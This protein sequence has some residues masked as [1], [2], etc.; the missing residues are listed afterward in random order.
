VQNTT[1]SRLLSASSIVLAVAFAGSAFAQTPAVDPTKPVTPA[2]AA[3]P[4]PAPATTTPAAA[5]ARAVESIVVT[6]S[7]IK[8]DAFSST[9]PIQVITNEDAE[10]EGIADAAEVIQGSTQ[11]SS[12]FQINSTFTGFVVEG[13]G[14][15]NS[16][17]LRGLGAQRSLILL[18]GKRMPPS[19]VRGQVGAVDLNALPGSMVSRYEFLKDGAS[20]IYGSDAIGGVINIITKT[21]QDGGFANAYYSG[22]ED[23]GGNTT[24]LDVSYGWNFDRGNIL[25]GAEYF[26]RTDLQV[27]DRDYLACSEDYVFNPD[28]GARADI[29]D[30]LTG[31]NKCFNLFQQTARVQAGATRGEWILDPSITTGATAGW[32]QIRVQAAGQPA[33]PTSVFLP[34]RPYRSAKS[35][36]RSALSPAERTTLFASGRYQ[37]PFGE[38]VEIKAEAL[39][40]LRKSEQNSFAQL[41]AFTGNQFQPAGFAGN[42][43][44]A[45]ADVL[46]LRPAFNEQEVTTTRFNVTLSGGFGDAIPFMND[47]TWEVYAQ[48]GKGQGDYGG[49]IIV[50]DAAGAGTGP[51]YEALRGCPTGSAA[52][53]KPFSWFNRDIVANGLTREDLSFIGA[54]EQGST[55]YKQDLFEASISGTLFKLPAGELGFATGLHFRTESINDV[56]GEF[57]R[58]GRNLFGTAAGITKGTDKVREAYVELDIPL[59][60]DAP[61]AERL[62]M[63]LSG[64]YTDYD[65]YGEDSVYKAALL[66]QIV[67]AV[68]FSTTYGTNY[69]A[70]A[71]YELFLA[72][73]SGFQGQGAI[74]ACVDWDTDPNAT[75]VRTCRALGLPPG[76]Q[77]V[78]PTATVFTGGGKGVLESETAD[79]FT[80]TLTWTPSFADL[81]IA[82]TYYEVEINNA[83]DQLGAANIVSLCQQ[84]RPGP[85]CGLFNRDLTG[86]AAT[87]PNFGSILTVQNSYIN[88]A[89]LRGRGI[90][91]E[92]RYRKE[93]SFGKL[94]INSSL[95]WNL[96][97]S[98]ELLGDVTNAEGLIYAPEFV[99]EFDIRFDR[100]DW[101]YSWN[102]D[103]IGRA[104]N[105]DFNELITGNRGL[106]LRRDSAQVVALK[107]F[108]EPQVT[109]DIAVRWTGDDWRVQV[110]V[111]NATYET[112][113][114]VSA[115]QVVGWY[116]R[117]GNTL[118][119]GPYD[120]IGRRFYFDI[121][122]SF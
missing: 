60:Q 31:T 23:G 76:Y 115:T 27:K 78:G 3:T 84:E 53:C 89:S 39:Y 59:L 90:D 75:I 110:G 44:G 32:R 71:L 91:V 7:R 12:A 93:L 102:M 50:G 112:P 104:S 62:T 40:S 122:R 4:P 8:R 55:E 45:A 30:P 68:K 81:S 79:N 119:G 67:P 109:H 41:F 85:Y 61:L 20:T 86:T 58:T 88:I 42:P 43:F 116:S 18:N 13:G 113:P 120:I 97:S 72:N 34:L 66:W 56:P 98:S 121:R 82:T 38:D 29:Q 57:S 54:F 106:A 28:T 73:Q 114:K 21:N 22:S 87:N 6:G 101:T 77:G 24:N 96:E 80:A 100:G 74:D 25:V 69:R 33:T 14:G 37:L 19:G 47:W 111:Q 35:D 95:A 11:A 1:K 92:A 99:G 49:D 36:T 9:S 107:A 16:V 63:N 65:S 64:R 51:F 48:T 52:N 10:L 83:V 105:Y 103:L 94:E 2:P 5:P 117:V 46:L 26:D 108:T 15:I 70:P 118:A 17:S